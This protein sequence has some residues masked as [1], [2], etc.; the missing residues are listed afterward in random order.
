SVTMNQA[1]FEITGL[2]FSTQYYVQMDAGTF[3]D[4]LNNNFHGISNNSTWTFTTVGPPPP[5][6]LG[7]NYNFDVCNTPFSNGFTQYSVIGPQKW[8]CTTFGID[9][10][11]TPTGSAPNGV[12]INGFSGTNIPNEDWLISPSFDLTGTTYPLLSFW[13]RTAFNGLPL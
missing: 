7:L 6:V 2:L 4:V 9:A 1:S 3:K 5:G 8:E 10:S 13:S 11:H 12:Q